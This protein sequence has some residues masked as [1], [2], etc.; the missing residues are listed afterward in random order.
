MEPL[1]R[2]GVSAEAE[3]STLLEAV[4]RKSLVKILRAGKKCLACMLVISKMWRSAMT[5]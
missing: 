5:L 1:F 4:A 2:E 3:E